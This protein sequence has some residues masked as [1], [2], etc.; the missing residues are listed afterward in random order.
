MSVNSNGYIQLGRNMK[1]LLLITMLLGVGYSQCISNEITL[2]V[3]GGSYGSEVSW[4]LSD[5]SSG[6]TGTFDLCLDG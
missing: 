6:G 2:V 4:D 1:N 5:G 3:G